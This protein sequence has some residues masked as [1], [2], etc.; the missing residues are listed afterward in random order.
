MLGFSNE[1]ASKITAAA[2]PRYKAI[3]ADLPEFEK[4]DRFKMNIVNCAMIAALTLNMPVRPSVD[5]LTKYYA[6]S[7][8]TRPNAL[9]L[10][11]ER[12]AAS[13]TEKDIAGMKSAA[14]KFRAAD[15]NPYSW[16]MDYYEY[17]GRQR[18]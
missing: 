14:A 11:Q 1:E 4:Q 18:V 5:K 13:I 9:V 3:I 15:R 6:D 2:K 16:N 8:M 7:M 17:P 12:K 10:P